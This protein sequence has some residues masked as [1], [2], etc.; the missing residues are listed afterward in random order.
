MNEK[1]VF[2]RADRNADVSPT[3]AE[4]TEPSLGY[5]GHDGSPRPD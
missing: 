1:L 5:L 4:P 2:P 3:P